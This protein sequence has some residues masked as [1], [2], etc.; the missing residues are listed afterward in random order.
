MYRV[1][2]PARY[3]STR[4]PGKPLLA[5][6][7]KPMIQRVYECARR[8][9]ALQV[10][11]ATDDERIARVARSFGAEVRMTAGTLASG[12]DRVAEVAVRERWGDTD[13]VVNVQ[14]D[15]P[16]MPEALI[17][18]V[19]AVLAARPVTDIATLAVPVSSV[20][21][22]LDPNVAKVVTDLQQRA[23]Y[24]SR[25]P[26]PWARDGAPAGVA[27][28][29]SHVGARRHLGIYAYRVSAL[30]RIAALPPSEHELLEQ[31]EQLRALDHGMDIRVA[32]AVV[33]PG[34]EVNT[35]A[36]LAAVEALLAAR[37]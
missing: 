36:D 34:I 26:I 14:G 4:L 18:Q 10:I 27:S 6:A 30:R 25:A 12:T 5:L 28:Q 20:S 9:G 16:L 35:P 15:E 2:I 3:G 1:V 31:L 17:D 8:S 29:S 32:D 13:I 22:L 37:G 23:L 33:A 24:F 7:G 21:V 11:V 19:A